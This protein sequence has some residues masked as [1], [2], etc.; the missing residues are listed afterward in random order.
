M[1][2]HPVPVFG[3]NGGLALR[4][5][6]EWPSFERFRLSGTA[7]LAPIGNGV[8]GTLA[9]RSG[10]YRIV[11]ERDFQRLLGLAADVERLRGGLQLV[12]SAVQAVERHRDDATVETLIQAVCLVR[13]LPSLPTRDG[14]A[15]IAPEGLSVDPD[16]DVDLNPAAL[17]GALAP[18]QPA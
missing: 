17:G 16:D 18:E 7:A 15:D 5:G 6:P 12:A 11:E 14:F 2:A 9:T 3:Q 4:P 13:D 8:V 10:R 1:N